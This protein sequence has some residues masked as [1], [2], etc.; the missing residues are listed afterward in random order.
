VPSSG[1]P[2]A[3][4]PWAISPPMRSH[5]MGP[6]G[7]AICR[8]VMP[9]PPFVSCWRQLGARARSPQLRSPLPVSGRSGLPGHTF[10]SSTEEAPA[11]SALS[12]PRRPPPR[13][14]RSRCTT[15]RRAADRD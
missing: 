3:A 8:R 6:R 5:A 4:S 12:A 11:R 7:I 13:A 15:R 10:F 1:S 2:H 9:C 14:F